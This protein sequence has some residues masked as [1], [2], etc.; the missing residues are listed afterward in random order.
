MFEG[1]PMDM[2]RIE[3]EAE[4]RI[5]AHRMG[6]FRILLRDATGAPVPRA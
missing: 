4:A 6:D 2:T 3:A 5:A 1:T